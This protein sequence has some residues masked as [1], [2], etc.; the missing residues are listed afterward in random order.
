MPAQPTNC[1]KCKNTWLGIGPICDD[2]FRPPRFIHQPPPTCS[3]CQGAHETVNC[4]A[5]AAHYY[6][7][8]TLYNNMKYT[9]KTTKRRT[10][11]FTN[12]YNSPNTPPPLKHCSK[13]KQQACIET[14]AGSICTSCN[15]LTRNQCRNCGSTS[16][17]GLSGNNLQFIECNDCRFIE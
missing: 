10:K 17:H 7:Q 5:A 2:C 9:R 8:G 15:A 11:P 3:F 16:T 14:K 1:Y 4:L 12:Y 13:C 6:Q